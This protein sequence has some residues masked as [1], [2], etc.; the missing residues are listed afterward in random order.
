MKFHYP[1]T[2]LPPADL[3][4]ALVDDLYEMVRVVS[5]EG[6]QTA[7]AMLPY[8]DEIIERHNWHYLGP[9]RNRNKKIYH[10]ATGA[11]YR[12]RE[13]KQLIT[14]EALDI[15]PQWRLRVLTRVASPPLE[16]WKE[17]RDKIVPANCAWIRAYLHISGYY[18][19]HIEPVSRTE[20][21][22]SSRNI[23]AEPLV[24]YY[25][26]TDPITGAVVDIPEGIEPGFQKD[27][28]LPMKEYV[29]HFIKLGMLLPVDEEEK[30]Q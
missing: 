20:L 19:A 30:P 27:I 15:F 13:Y 9:R 16:L 26:G 28:R 24:N 5:Y 11:F 4:E 1:P 23:S 25:Q 17:F 10:I 22:T 14:P 2:D 29:Q 7:R 12:H 3:S 18:Y 21:R 8:F 6:G